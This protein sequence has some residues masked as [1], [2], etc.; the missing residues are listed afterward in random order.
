VQH[1][2]KRGPGFTIGSLALLGLILGGLVGASLKL[3]EV[4]S[5]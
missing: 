3:I 1:P 4:F 2:D 5:S